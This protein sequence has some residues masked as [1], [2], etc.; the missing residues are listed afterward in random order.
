MGGSGYKWGKVNRQSHLRPR[1]IHLL[2]FGCPSLVTVTW[3]ISYGCPRSTDSHGCWCFFVHEPV[4]SRPST[5]RL[6]N[7]LS[8]VLIW[9]ADL[10]S[11]RLIPARSDTV[12]HATTI[13]NRGWQTSLRCTTHDA[14]LPD[15]YCWATFG[16]NRCG[17][18]LLLCSCRRARCM[19]TGR[20]PQH[21]MYNVSQRHRRRIEPRLQ[22]ICTKICQSSAVCFLRYICEQT[23]KQTNKP[24]VTFH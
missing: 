9:A 18:F 5:A 23:N 13:G 14:C 22:A 15:L 4:L 8:Y 24:E 21:Q 7:R 10:F 16:L 1:P 2:L 17:I 3:P 19:K 11:A 12:K 6:A 20:H